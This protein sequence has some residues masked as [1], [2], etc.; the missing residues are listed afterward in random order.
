MTPG[1]NTGTYSPHLSQEIV[2][3]QD[4]SDHIL[5]FSDQSGRRKCEDLPRGAVLALLL[6]EHLG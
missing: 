1:C 4:I 5:G 3:K 6:H 2:K